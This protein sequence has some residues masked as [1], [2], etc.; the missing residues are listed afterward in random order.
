MGVFNMFFVISRCVVGLHDD[1]AMTN[2]VPRLDC[3]NVFFNAPPQW[4]SALGSQLAPERRA[5][6]RVSMDSDDV[7]CSSVYSDCIFKINKLSRCRK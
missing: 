3:V 7:Q 5:R 1:S 4:K 2:F 6:T